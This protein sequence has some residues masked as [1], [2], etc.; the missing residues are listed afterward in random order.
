MQNLWSD[1]TRFL[2]YLK[3]EPYGSKLPDPYQ[4]GP[5]GFALCSASC[6]KKASTDRKHLGKLGKLIQEGKGLVG[7]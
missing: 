1:T 3:R 7:T 4:T 2:G 6:T 5:V